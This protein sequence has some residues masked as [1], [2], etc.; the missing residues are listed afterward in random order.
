MT[1]HAQIN[2][3]NPES[4]EVTPSLHV[5]GD[6]LGDDAIVHM[7]RLRMTEIVQLRKEVEESAQAE[8]RRC[9]ELHAKMVEELWARIAGCDMREYADQLDAD[10]HGCGAKFLADLAALL[11]SKFGEEK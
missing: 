8:R 4:Q 7:V 6:S 1:N 11:Q 5:L 3:Q 2:P 10:L 9:G